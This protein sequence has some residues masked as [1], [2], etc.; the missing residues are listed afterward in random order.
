MDGI[1]EINEKYPYLNPENSG[2]WAYGN[3]DDESWYDC[4]PTGW[5]KLFLEMCDDI[6]TVLEKYNIPKTDLKVHQVKEKYGD[7]RFYYGG[8]SDPANDEIH[9]I[10]NEYSNKSYYTCIECGKAATKQ[11][12]SWICPYC[13]NCIGNRKYI[14]IK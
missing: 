7:L 11:S 14:D 8:L 10:V 13:D 9:R 2:D 5:R 3:C 1:K 12:R 6:N 4:V